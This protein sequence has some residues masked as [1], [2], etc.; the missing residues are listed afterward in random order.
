VEGGRQTVL[1]YYM[2]AKV[3]PGQVVRC[4]K[5]PTKRPA[6]TC[7]ECW[8]TGK[9]A[10]WLR[11]DLLLTVDTPVGRGGQDRARSAGSAKRAET[12]PPGAHTTPQCLPTRAVH[13]G[14]VVST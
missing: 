2:R 3:V 8:E 12:V 13:P 14:L 1:V 9:Q 10:G 7:C 6:R 4:G 5:G 11:G